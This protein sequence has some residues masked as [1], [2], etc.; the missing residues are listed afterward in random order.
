MSGHRDKY[1]SRYIAHGRCEFAVW[2]PFRNT[3]ELVITGEDRKVIPMGKDASGYWSVVLDNIMPGTRYLYRLDGV[4]RADPASHLQPEGVLGPS[5]TVDHGLFNWTDAGWKGLALSDMVI[6]EIHT[7]TFT[8]E[9]TF[10]SV[11]PRLGELAELGINAIE[12][13]PVAQ[14]PGDRNWGYDGVF[15]FSVQNTYGGPEGLKT[16]VDACHG[17][18]IAV[19]LDVV[20]NHFG[21]EG[22]YTDDFGPYHTDRYATPW[23]KAINFD[24][25]Y[26]D[27]VRDFFIENAVHWSRNYHIDGL[28]LD[29]VHNIFDFSA[30][31]FLKELKE[32]ANAYSRESGRRF[33]LVAESDLNDPT[34]FRDCAL[35]GYGLDAGWCEDFHHSL[36][37]LL[38]GERAGY[39]GDFGEMAQFA[40]SLEEG[41][42]Y[43]GQYSAFRKKR[44]GATSEEIPKSRFIV[45]SQNHDQT[46]NRA[47]GERLSQLAPFEALKLAAGAVLL[48]PY[49]PLLFMGEE[50]G[51]TAPYLYFISHLDETT[52]EAVRKGRIKDLMDSGWTGDPPDPRSVETYLRSKIR[53]EDRYSGTHATLLRFYRT[54]IGLRKDNPAL[55]CPGGKV[56]TRCIEEEK[57]VLMER[58]EG[59]F[60]V[61]D[62]ADK[63]RTIRVDFPPGEW[64]KVLDSAETLWEGPGSRLPGRAA[65]PAELC[66]TGLSVALYEKKGTDLG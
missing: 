64:V 15:P 6:Y 66:L 3:V 49:V 33:H 27:E 43:S 62:F 52:A 56:K 63:S 25:P 38:T 17:K 8:P 1:L 2:A 14:F 28:R 51:E 50:Y 10:E 31:P 45:F 59:A 61:F 58:A 30:R 23:G 36:H 37:T 21:P 42:V 32:R 46:G 24:G 40:K 12:L 13:M 11:I 53:W 60:I 4:E 26:S 35:Y 29:A 57:V 54:L 9:G 39:Y 7:G 5:E 34:I 65:S 41:F 20:Y 47:L 18:G 55:K 16:L 44:F 48:S 22:N 19:I